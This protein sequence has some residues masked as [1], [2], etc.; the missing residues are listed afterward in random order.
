MLQLNT[1]IYQHL[2]QYAKQ[3][4]LALFHLT[5]DGYILDISPSSSALFNNNHYYHL[6]NKNIIDVLLYFGIENNLSI[7][8]GKLK[9]TK[10]NLFLTLTL[11]HN[12]KSQSP[13]FILSIDIHAIFKSTLG[14]YTII[15]SIP[16]PVYC[17]DENSQYIFANPALNS[18]AG[19]NM[20]GLTDFD[21]PWTATT[22]SLINNDQLV[23]NNNKTI[24]VIE[25][26]ANYKGNRQIAYSIKS[27]IYNK[28]S[29]KVIGVFGISI[30]N[31]YQTMTN[32]NGEVSLSIGLD[33]SVREVECVNL[34]IQ[35]FSSTEI[36][37][38]LNISNRTA[39]DHIKNIKH[40]MNCPSL[41][42]LGYILGKHF[43]HLLHY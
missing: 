16:Y 8:K 13:S 39:Q 17:K 43:S 12:S 19:K 36:S 9:I 11:I 3:M 32:T 1:T 10:K 7:K 34:L 35:G 30:F 22:K 5:P 2:V 28:E 42:K 33:L 23:M 31:C 27:P 15:D 14:I 21:S 6:M 18:H 38:K 37:K 20:I 29:N 41:F 25:K 24:M 26:L 4:D 40:K